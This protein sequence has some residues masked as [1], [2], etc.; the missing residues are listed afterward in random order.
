[1]APNNSSIDG[2]LDPA[3]PWLAD[4]A[5]HTASIN[6][7]KTVVVPVGANSYAPHANLINTED[8]GTAAAGG[9]SGAGSG[10]GSSQPEAPGYK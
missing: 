9:G 6:Y 8:A 7:N 10:G 2:S 4:N 5:A 3:S 1:M